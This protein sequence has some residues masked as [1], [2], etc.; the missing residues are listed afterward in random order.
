MDYSAAVIIPAAVTGAQPA[1]WAAVGYA[2]QMCADGGANRRCA[3]PIA[4][5]GDTRA[6]KIEDIGL[7]TEKKTTPGRIGGE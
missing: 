2:P 6:A 4:E 1:I 3:V 5:R 7:I